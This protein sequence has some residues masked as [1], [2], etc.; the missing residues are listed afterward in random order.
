MESIDWR[1]GVPQWWETSE[2]DAIICPVVR[3]LLVNTGDLSSYH[4][5]PS[6][7]GGDKRLRRRPPPSIYPN[8]MH[9]N[10][11]LRWS[12]CVTE[13]KD[14][15]S[16]LSFHLGDDQL[17]KQLEWPVDRRRCVSTLWDVADDIIWFLQSYFKSLTPS[18]IGS[19]R[20]LTP[21]QFMAFWVKWED[22]LKS[23]RKIIS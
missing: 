8:V 16:P 10:V 4:L 6:V 20:H 17:C 7:Q 5:P 22:L 2:T 12:P 19:F 21:P 11:V 1:S 23:W 15:E 14:M 13:Q 9:R 3:L 18:T